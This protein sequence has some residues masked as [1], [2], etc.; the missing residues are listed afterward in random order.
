MPLIRSPSTGFVPKLHKTSHGIHLKQNKG[1]SH[2]FYAL[3]KLLTRRSVRKHSHDSRTKIQRA[4]QVT[5]NQTM[6]PTRKNQTTATITRRKP[7]RALFLQWEGANLAAT[8]SCLTK[9][10]TITQPCTTATITR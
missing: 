8:A 10:E 9:M 7:P 2:H 6:A 3:E 1:N 5:Q 4:R